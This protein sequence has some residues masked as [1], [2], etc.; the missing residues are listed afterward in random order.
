MNHLLDS[1]FSSSIHTKF[2]KMISFVDDFAGRLRK[3]QAVLQIDTKCP[4]RAP[5]RWIYITDTK[6]QCAQESRNPTM[7][8]S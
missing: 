8:S 2:K 3:R 1:V 6:L 5:T 7:H 4:V